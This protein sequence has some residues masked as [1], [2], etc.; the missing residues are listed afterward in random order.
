M[1]NGKKHGIENESRDHHGSV[2]PTVITTSTTSMM[3]RTNC[4]HVEGANRVSA[5]NTAALTRTSAFHLTRAAAAIKILQIPVIAVALRSQLP[6]SSH[7][8]STDHGAA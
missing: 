7:P 8:I 2:N 5:R 3:R 4:A 6:A 1:K